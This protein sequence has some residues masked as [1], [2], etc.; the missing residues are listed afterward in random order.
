MSVPIW[1][2]ALPNPQR[3]TYKAQRAEGR[4]AKQSGGPIGYRR[5]FSSMPTLVSLA[6]DVP[7]SLKAIFDEFYD[8]T[9]EGGTKTFWMPDAV[10]QDWP[11]LAQDGAYLQNSEGRVLLLAKTDLCIFGDQPPVETI[12]GN[13]FVINFAVQ[14]LP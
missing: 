10:T 9:T 6:I 3:K 5:R 12:Q 1:P 8:V 11:M 2:K 14:V 7:R 4:L 13:R